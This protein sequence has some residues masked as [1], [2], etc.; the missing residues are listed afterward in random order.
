MLHAYAIDASRLRFNQV[1]VQAALLL[2]GVFSQLALHRRGKQISDALK[3]VNV[4]RDKLPR[5]GRVYAKYPNGSICS[6]N[7]RAYATYHLVI[8]QQLRTG[9]SSLG[10]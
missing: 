6:A 4:V 3:E 8:V 7:N 9:E 2:E 10:S 5:P 1:L